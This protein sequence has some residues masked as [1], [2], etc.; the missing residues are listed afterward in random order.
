MKNTGIVRKLDDLGRITLPK[1]MRRVYGINIGDP[2]EIYSD[3]DMIVLKKYETK[4]EHC[5]CGEMDEKNC[6]V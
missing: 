5:S 3:E 4:R 6:V 2:I 1:E